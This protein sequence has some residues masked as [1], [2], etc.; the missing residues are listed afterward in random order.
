MITTGIVPGFPA[1][2]PAHLDQAWLA[3]VS[4]PQAAVIAM[5]AD[6]GVTITLKRQP[7]QAWGI[8]LL[9]TAI[10]V[11]CMLGAWLFDR[12]QHSPGYDLPIRYNMTKLY[13]V[14]GMCLMGSLIALLVLAAGGA[15]GKDTVLTAVA[16]RLTVDRYVSGDHVVRTYTPADCRAIW[17]DSAIGIDAGPCP[18]SIGIFTPANVQLGAAEILG[19]VFWADAA[20]V[21]RNVR[22]PLAAGESV[23][24]LITAREGSA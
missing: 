5:T 22:T 2:L 3:I 24:I 9:I 8:A 23:K 13:L 1:S 6:N 18:F 20:A 11:L 12:Y 4:K 17:V 7:K 21:H 16:G 19:T 14:A 10:G 15:E